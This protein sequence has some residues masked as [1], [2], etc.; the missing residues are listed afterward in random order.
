MERDVRASDNVG[1]SVPV[2]D[3]QPPITDD[4]HASLMDDLTP[5]ASLLFPP[6]SRIKR[7]LTILSDALGPS[8]SILPREDLSILARLL[9]QDL[10][11]PV[12]ELTVSIL[13]DHGREWR[14]PINSAEKYGMDINWDPWNPNDDPTVDSSRSHLASL[15]WIFYEVVSHRPD[16]KMWSK[17]MPI[18]KGRGY[19][20]AL[21]AMA[22]NAT[23]MSHIWYALVL[24]V[25]TVYDAIGGYAWSHTL[26]DEAR[27]SLLAL[28]ADAWPQIE[29]VASSGEGTDYN[30][31]AFESP[32]LHM[33]LAGMNHYRA[34]EAFLDLVTRPIARCDGV[35]AP[36]VDVNDLFGDW[37]YYGRN[38]LIKMKEETLVV[39][40][41]YNMIRSVKYVGY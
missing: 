2:W 1:L 9:G 6:S 17:P 14:S 36:S 12:Y 23:L 38:G 3:T 22:S 15:D 5:Y 29:E 4:H 19:Y 8:E 41:R 26:S 11:T 30:T 33:D 34:L 35:V 18:S 37:G 20:R 16:G 24:E 25:V 40:R 27:A 31:M 28:V 39:L 21:H 13:A 32:A 7:G 10:P